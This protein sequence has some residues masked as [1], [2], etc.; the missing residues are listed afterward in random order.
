MKSFYA[1]YL[2]GLRSGEM[3]G[4][5]AAIAGLIWA[6]CQAHGITLDYVRRVDGVQPS[7]RAD[8]QLA[9]RRHALPLDR[10]R[11]I[12]RPSGR[13]RPRVRRHVRQ[14]TGERACE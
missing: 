4:V 9:E 2:D 7:T 8:E 6:W 12:P 14:R 10:G 11:E 1:V 3:L 13:N 5:V